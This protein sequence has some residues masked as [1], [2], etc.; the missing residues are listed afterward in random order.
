MNSI[1]SVFIALAIG[2]CLGDFGNLEECSGRCNINPNEC[3]DCCAEAAIRRHI[4]DV[5]VGASC[6]ENECMCTDIE[7]R[8][9]REAN[10]PD[11]H[12]PQATV[13][14]KRCRPP[15]CPYPIVFR[16]KL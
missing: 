16:Y 11:D 1:I 10:D 4:P 15:L 13:S 9:K 2:H 12:R 8:K 5:F 6:I 3:S 14:Y 7:N